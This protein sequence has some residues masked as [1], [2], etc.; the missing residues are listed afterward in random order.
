[1]KMTLLLGC[2]C[3]LVPVVAVAGVAPDQPNPAGGDSGCA[4]ERGVGNFVH[5]TAGAAET[6]DLIRAHRQFGWSRDRHPDASDRLTAPE[7][8]PR[9]ES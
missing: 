1:M 4:V 7:P 2:L 6:E 5:D 8:H 3:G 9:S